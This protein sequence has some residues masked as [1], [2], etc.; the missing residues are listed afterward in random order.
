MSIDRRPYVD[1]IEP[2]VGDAATDAAELRARVESV[3]KGG[4]RAAVLGFNDGLVTNV[5]LILAVAGASGAASGGG[6]EVRIAGFA[7][8][9]AGAFSMAAGEWVSVR[10]Q[11]D[12]YQGILAELRHLVRR[13]PKLVLDELTSKLVDAG[14]ATD[15]AQR[16]STELPL[17]ESKFLD[18]SAQTVFGFNSHELG[19]PATAAI[20]SLALFSVG[21]AVPLVPWFVTDGGAALAASVVGAAAA[22]VVVGGWVSRSSGRSPWPGAVR[23]LMIVAA[24]AA[25][26]F[27]IGSLFG[28]VIA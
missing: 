18:F 1:R 6:S 2:E 12:L 25:V 10:S 4:A 21:A 7:S 23:Q 3:A 20:S 22:S 14:F 13:N 19:S 11:V 24:A 5:C 15:T 8:L 9:I 28:T 16:A 17:D 27:G 26:T